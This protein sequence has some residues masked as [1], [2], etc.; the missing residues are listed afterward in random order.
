MEN[1]IEQRRLLD[2][3]AEPAVRERA[4][5][6]VD[7]VAVA[8]KRLASPE[9][10]EALHDFRVALRRLRI[11]LRAYDR[12][13]GVSGKLQARLHDIA[14]TTNGA[15]DAE[16]VL[17]WLNGQR[18]G[19]SDH[20]LF[21]LNWLAVKLEEERRR[22]NELIF[23]RVPAE[24][25]AQEQKLR[26]RL[27]R[28]V[29][30]PAHRHVFAHAASKQILVHTDELEK[31]LEAVLS[32]DD[33]AAAHRAR[34]GAKH[35]RYLLEPL[36][37]ELPD[38]VQIVKRLA[39]LQDQLGTLHDASVRLDRLIDAT[40]TAALEDAKTLISLIMAGDFEEEL[41]SGINYH[42]TQPGLLVLTHRAK[43]SETALFNRILERLHSNE[44]RSLI[45]QARIIGESL[46]SVHGH[47]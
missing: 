28:T 31:R 34:I 32:V 43:Q 24:W 7:K 6:L 36:R 4:L 2:M 14:Q 37:D 40:E 10:A 38:V 21:G 27:G 20:Q 39:D 17:A 22:V 16:V 41:L 9:D 1:L 12:Y 5:K 45:N 13:A 19:F 35:L 23:S 11:W 25:E 8:C 46:G 30:H 15:R 47:D 33:L 42:D 18:G 29:E 26:K 3:P 44:M